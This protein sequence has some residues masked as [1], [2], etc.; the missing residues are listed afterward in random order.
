[1]P[2]VSRVAATTFVVLFLMNMLDYVDRWALSGVLEELKKDLNVSDAALGSLNWFFLISYSIFGIFMGWAGDR[3]RR[4]R[5]LAVGVGVWSIATVGTGLAQDLFQLRLARSF[6]GIGEATYGILAPSILMDLFRR[7]RR[8]RVLSAFYIAMPLGYA[9]GVKAGGY[10]AHNWGSWRLAFFIVGVPGFVAAVAALFLPEPARGQSDVVTDDLP[11]PEAS[12]ISE[13]T[14]HAVEDSPAL[15]PTRADYK[16]LLVNSSYTY[17]V[18]GM[19]AYTFAFGG[20]AYWLPTYLKRAR[21]L[22]PDDVDSMVALTGFIAAIVGMYGGGWLADRI[23][24]KVPSA[25]FLVSGIS[26]LAAAPCVVAG[27]TAPPAMIMAWLF[28]A[29]VLMFA[30]VGPSNAI[31]ANVVLP[32]MRATAYAIMNFFI[33]FLG[34]VWSP[35]LMGHVSDQFGQPSMMATPVGELLARLGFQ[36]VRVNE[37]P[38]NLGVGMLLVVPAL[39]MGGVVL[40][41]GVRHLPREMALMQARWRANVLRAAAASKVTPSNS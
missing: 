26:M 35:L 12:G 6:L 16:D 21:G 32:N 10:I 5:L 7:E 20:L 11:R 39:V 41:A 33:H 27:L 19:A 40:L 23:A 29:Q 17:T 3:Y 1:L 18:F 13:A 4:T 15:R 31:V 36:P 9:I 8:A 38:T 2:P 14:L 37:V 24:K 28:I 25:L 34:D 22:P 30:N